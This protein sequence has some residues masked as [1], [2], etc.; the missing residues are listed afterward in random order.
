M[1]LGIDVG[2]ITTKVVLTDGEDRVIAH[3][4]LRNA[5]KPIAAIQEGIRR[6]TRQ[7]GNPLSIEGVGATGSARHLAA[8]LVGADVVKNEI[9]AHALA[10]ID[11]VPDAKTIIEIGGQDSKIIILREQVVVDF[12]MNTVCAAGTGSF[13]DQQASRLGISIEDFG[14][15]ALR[16]RNRVRIAGRCTVFAE[17]DMIHKQQLGYQ[18]EDIIAG[19]SDSLVKNYLN[20]VSR[21]KEI[22]PPVV[23][24]GG[25]AANKGIRQA[26]ERELGVEIIVPPHFDLMGAIG[27]AKLAR[28]AEPSKTCFKGV[29]VAQWNFSTRSFECDG[30]G[31]ACD[32]MELVA[33]GEVVACWGD[34]CGK[35][36]DAFES[37]HEEGRVEIRSERG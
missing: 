34:T 5:G 11:Y 26:F 20:N 23:F 7:A 27:A 30:C 4:Y 16:S 10:V 36:S 1:Y 29:E 33:E 35:H 28:R 8:Y 6:I 9:T 13:L 24:Q 2:S 32:V 21:G 25:V 31:N 17:T 37:T 19:L 12:A 3:A 18:I 14:G 15:R 22:L